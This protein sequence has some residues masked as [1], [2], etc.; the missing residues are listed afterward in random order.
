M[1]NNIIYVTHVKDFTANKENYRTKGK[2]IH[3]IPRLWTTIKSIK[4]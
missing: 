2:Q 1:Y 3:T 4:I